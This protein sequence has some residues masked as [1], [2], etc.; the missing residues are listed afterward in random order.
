[1]LYEYRMFYAEVQ[2]QIYVLVLDLA[3]SSPLGEKMATMPL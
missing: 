3:R 1:M 2:L